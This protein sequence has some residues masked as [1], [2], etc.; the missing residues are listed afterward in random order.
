QGR[1]IFQHVLALIR[2]IGGR[3]QS[4][5]MSRMGL[6]PQAERTHG[7]A[8]ARRVERKVRVQQ[9]RNVVLPE[10]QIALVNLRYP[11]KF[12]QIL[13]ESAFRVMHESAILS[14]TNAGQF[15]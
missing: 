8:A 15:L 2:D 3:A 14:E 13:N 12:V 11:R 9:K 1:K 10:I 7:R 5:A 6:R 4:P